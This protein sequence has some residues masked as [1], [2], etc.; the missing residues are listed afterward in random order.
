MMNAEI[1]VPGH[2]RWCEFL[3]GLSQAQRC[4][5][6]TDHA[7]KL[8][9]RMQGVDPHAS[10]RALRELGGECDCSILFDLVELDD[11]CARA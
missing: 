11:P 10:L 4:A 1:M 5:L 7:E 9:S 2:P 3:N 8:L 6:T